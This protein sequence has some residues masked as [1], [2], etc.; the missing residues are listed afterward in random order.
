MSCLLYYLYYALPKLR[1]TGCVDCV[2]CVVVSVSG[3]V[4]VP[5]RSLA[6][7]TS[8]GMSLSLP[9]QSGPAHM[10]GMTSLSVSEP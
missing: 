8:A 2:A 6:L 9:L 10:L 7:P 5:R 3:R 1:S 4:S